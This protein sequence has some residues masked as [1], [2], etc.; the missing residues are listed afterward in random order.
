[1]ARIMGV[2]LVRVTT[3]D[4]VRLEGALRLP[5]AGVASRLPID[6]I[7]MHHGYA[8][9]FYGIYFFEQMAEE[10]LARGCAVLRVNSRGHDLAF[11]SPTGRLGGAFENVDDCRH[12]WTAWTDLAEQS[13]FR[14]IGLW[15]QSL[16]AVKTIFFLAVQGDP[17][18]VRAIASSPPRFPHAAFM[19]RDEGGVFSRYYERAR[20]LVA[21]GQ[22]DAVFAADIPTNLLV[23][24][25]VYLD[26]YGPEER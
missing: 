9:N 2:E 20:R 26:K 22:P 11:N 19:A 10:F 21:D 12:D 4:G 8:G 23:T 25:S 3:A 18:I 5:E 24:A 1:M 6:A 7:V 14:R 13:G 15:G 16:G 17:R